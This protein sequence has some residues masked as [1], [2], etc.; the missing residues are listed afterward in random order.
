MTGWTFIRGV[1]GFGAN[2]RPEYQEGVYLDYNKAF[3][4]LVELNT[5]ALKENPSDDPFYEEGY[6]EDYFP[7]DDIEAKQAY[8]AEDW[9]RFDEI[10]KKHQCTDIIKI[11]EA[12]LNYEEP[13]FGYYT[14]VE[15]E[16]YE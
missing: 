8:E 10:M 3:A 7:E 16:I 13:P 9:D 12:L 4:R 6:G 14:L 2:I 15:V 11:C 5:Q 1:D